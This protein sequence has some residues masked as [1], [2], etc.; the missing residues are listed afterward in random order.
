MTHEG[1]RARPQPSDH[2]EG[3]QRV[4]L[5]AAV[6]A[7]DLWAAVEAAQYARI[8]IHEDAGSPEE[9]QAVRAFIDAFSRCTE[10]WEET[11][12]ES[13]NL[14]LEAL[15]TVL[16]PL[17]DLGLAV[18]WGTVDR[19]LHLPDGRVQPIPLAVVSVSR[20]DAAVAELSLPAEL[21][22]SSGGA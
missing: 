2:A 18:H 12:L 15:G 4:E 6:E 17:R 22:V 20:S 9:A 16:R 3:Q 19:S 7:R 1:H 8:V 11:R 21:E 14:M 10:T 5:C 13:R